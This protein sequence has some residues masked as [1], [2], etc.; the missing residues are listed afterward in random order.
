MKRWLFCLLSACALHLTVSAHVLDQ[1]LQVAQIAL[2]PDGVRIEMRLVPGV[3][4]AERF[5]ARIDSDGNG[6][7]SSAEEHAYARRVLQDLTLEVDGRPAPLALV[8]LQFPSRGEINE[9][10]GTIRLNCAAEI[11]LST[12][13]DHQLFFLNNHLPEFSA[14]LA[15]ALV[16]ATTKIK[17]SGQERDVQQHGLRINFRAT[18]D[19]TLGR[20]GWI[21]LL[22]LSFGLVGVLL[23]KWLHGFALKQRSVPSAF[24][25]WL[26]MLSLIMILN[27]SPALAHEQPVT[28][29]MLD[30][31][32]DRVAMTLH[33]PLNEL[34]LAFGN[35]VSVSPETTLS[36]WQPQ[37]QEYLLSHIHPVTQGQSWTVTVLDMQVQKAEQTQSG[38]FQEIVVRLALTPPSGVSTRRFTLNYDLIMHQVV[39]H[40]A[41]VS[42]R[43]DWERGQAASEEVGVIRVNTE[44]AK[45]EPF[46]INL[47]RGSWWAGFIGMVLLGIQ[48]IKEGSDHLLFLLALL[49]PATL[50]V[51]GRR[52]GGFGGSRYSLVR[53]LKIVTAFTLGHSVTLLIGALGWLR[54]P[55]Q[56]V[57]V[58][59]AFSILVSALHAIRPLF[60]GKEIYVASGFGLVHGLAFATVLADLHLSAGPMALSIL[61]FNLGIELMQ[62]FVI[63]VTI[64]WLVLLSMTPLYVWVRGGSALFA[65]AAALGWMANRLTGRANFIDRAM[66]TATEYAPFGILLLV[67]LAV[68]AYLARHRTDENQRSSAHE[69]TK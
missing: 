56:P 28:L 44:T 53:L 17:I 55:Q 33:V 63:A 45:I 13:G 18:P 46:E 48:H 65:A 12:K 23:W 57:E 27:A 43:H 21:G 4:V 30:V 62:L 67:L 31:A 34:E 51:N 15:N 41:L 20:P 40:K 64:P 26:M 2:A 14:Y 7:I 61:G 8:S 24:G 42:L 5:L 25:Q 37:F 50:L 1:Y 3:Q 11:V 38:P 59:I 9:G 36:R 47:E 19:A 39:T 68:P 69:L 29:V 6:Q 49:L 22:L 58:L 10:N 60:P 35:Q 66:Q 16:P 52:W 32:P 54:L